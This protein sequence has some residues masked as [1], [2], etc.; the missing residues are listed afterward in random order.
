MQLGDLVSSDT[1]FLEALVAVFSEVRRPR[2]DLARRAPQFERLADEPEPAAIGSRRFLRNTEVLDLRIVENLIDRIDRTARNTDFIENLDPFGAG[3]RFRRLVDFGIELVTVLQPQLA[4][5]V[6]RRRNPLRTTD[7]AAEAFPD[8]G[9]GNR[10]IQISV[11]GFEY[12]RWNGGRVIIAG[13]FRDHTFGQEP[14]CLKVEH[15]NLRLQ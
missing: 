4:C 3:F 2:G 14:R 8:H 9:A 5:L 6:V 1:E 12:A 7:R 15:E 11:A 13:L 10:N